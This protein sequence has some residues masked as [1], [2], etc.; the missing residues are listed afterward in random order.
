VTS[1]I[2]LLFALVAMGLFFTLAYAADTNR[3][4]RY[5]VFTVLILANVF[6]AMFASAYS[7]VLFLGSDAVTGMTAPGQ[8]E[9]T[10]AAASVF[11]NPDLLNGLAAIG[12]ILLTLAVL[13]VIITYEPFRRPLARWIPIDP[14]SLVHLVALEYA[15][16]L[17]GASALT[18]VFVSAAA[19]DPEMMGQ[20]LA[21]NDNLLAVAWA[22]AAGFVALALLGVG[23]LVRRDLR[24]SLQRLG[25]TRSFSV[26]WWLAVTLTALGTSILVDVIW[27]AL[28]PEGMEAVSRISGELFEPF[29]AAGFIGMLTV[30]LSAGIGEELVFRGAA[31]ERFGLAFT[32]FL[33]A[34][35]HTQY[36]VSPALIQV[37]LVAVVLG[38]A[39]VRANTTTCIVAHASYNMVLVGLAIWAPE[40]SP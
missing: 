1:L 39:R 14:S 38:L 17:L 26:K 21:D 31:Q 3:F 8:P 20:L 28:D 24:A 36:T 25:V 4:L 18:A 30:G 5:L 11:A 40:L 12:P 7:L 6:A 2:F 32:S 13:G 34:V 35:M 22:Q 9:T 33:F 29:I 16:A 15:L 10:A 23:F 19:Q 27:R 37:F